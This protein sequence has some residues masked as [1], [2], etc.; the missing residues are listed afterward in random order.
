MPSDPT[1]GFPQQLGYTV[2]GWFEL[3]TVDDLLAKLERDLEK[4]RLRPHDVDLAFNFF[5]TAEHL[6]DW[7]YPGREGEGA[8][9]NARGQDVLLQI[10]SH[11]A[12]GA[13]HFSV[14]AKHHQSVR[15]T[16]R[17]GGFMPKGAFPKRAWPVGFWGD[18]LYVEL[19]GDAA[20]LLG[21]RVVVL[22]LAERVLANWQRRVGCAS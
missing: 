16:N 13:K 19:E 4:L 1:V 17:S 22:D 3:R 21:P 15:D 11:L 12:N 6:L 2:K 9:R 7:Q 8:R 14:E 5:V 18:Y 20:A 10:T